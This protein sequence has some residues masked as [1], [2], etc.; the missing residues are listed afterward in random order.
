MEAGSGV[1][2]TSPESLLDTY[3][4]ERHPVAARALQYTMAQG[5]LQRR[6]ER[7][8]ALVDVVA[9][10]ASLDA[11]RKA[12]AGRISGLDIHYDLGEGHPL[13]GRRVPDLDLV[14]ADGPR[15]VFELLH[16]AKPVLL[17]L[18]QPGS[19][20]I[21]PW[22]DRVQLIDAEYAGVW[23]LPVLGEVTAPASVLI[24]PDGYV[25]WV[26]DGTDRGL[27]DA[28]TTWFGPPSPPER[29]G[30]APPGDGAL[31]LQ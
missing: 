24:R 19:L 13:L 26:G 4:D 10:I 30:Q 17:D 1:K 14:T 18:G 2:G 16:G 5:V 25:A 23:E 20:D 7:M 31:A 6:D 21:G 15:R 9:E 12:L 3:Q 28:L 8:K 27:T 29:E 11:P 22:A